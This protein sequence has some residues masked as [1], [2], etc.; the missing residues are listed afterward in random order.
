[1]SR[2]RTVLG[3]L[4]I[5]SAWLP[6]VVSVEPAAADPPHSQLEL[7]SIRSG[8]EAFVTAFNKGDAK[9]IGK[10]W[11]EKGEYIDD[12][13]RHFSGRKEIEAGYAEF[14]SANPKVKIHLAI[15]SVRM[16]S[17]DVAIEEGRAEIAPQPTGSPGYTKYVVVHNKV[18]GKWLMASVRD[19][20]V[21]KP[22]SYT[23]IADLEWLIGS[24]MAEEHGTKLESDCQWIANKSFVKRSFTTTKHDGTQISGVQ[25]IGWNPALRCVQSWEFSHDGG[26]AVGTWTPTIGGWRATMHGVTGDGSRTSAVTI[27]RRLD[28]DA[29]SWKSVQRTIGDV[30]LPDTDEI[31][32]KRQ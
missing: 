32:I 13:G 25:L 6:M 27:L 1:M 10:L 15:E 2:Y 30:V 8:S 18:D 29:Y 16:V 11:T 22:S 28:D 17:E 5:S 31:V 24:W 21:A 14:F 19:S 20:F 4:I 7:A 26:H 23:E 12:S 3:L 9:A